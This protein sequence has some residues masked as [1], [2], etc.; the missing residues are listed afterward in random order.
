MNNTVDKIKCGQIFILPNDVF[1]LICEFCCKDYRNLDD[2]VV[3]ITNHF[4]ETP[5]IIKQEDAIKQ[6]DVVKQ[7]DSVN[8]E[9]FV[10]QEDSVNQEDSLNQEDSVNQEDLVTQQDVVISCDSEDESAPPEISAEKLTD[11][12]QDIDDSQAESLTEVWELLSVEDSQSGEETFQSEQN[13]QRPTIRVR[14]FQSTSAFVNE[15]TTDRAHIVEP[16]SSHP[17]RSLLRKETVIDL[18]EENQTNNKKIPQARSVSEKVR[19][20]NFECKICDLII[21]TRFE[22]LDHIN[23]H[24]GKRPHKCKFCPEQF[25]QYSGLTTHI[26]NKHKKM[27]KHNCSGCGK[28]FAKRS[29]LN[30]HFRERHLPDNDPRRFFSCKICNIKFDR[31]HKLHSHTRTHNQSSSVLTCDYC[32]RQFNSLSIIELHMQIHSGTN[33]QNYNCKNC[34]RK[35][36]EVGPKLRHE[37][38]CTVWSS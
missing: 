7:E 4:P 2:F 5:T 31:L 14:D 28:Q 19:D 10:M 20:G 25:A 29:K 27:K 12:L 26:K 13:T 16:V 32:K 18:T 6:E 3:H 8:Q 1:S 37:R 21:Y 11:V 35:F 24:T 9:D 38:N 34:N 17:Q 22:F 30:Y 15:N 33:K 23:M 36:T